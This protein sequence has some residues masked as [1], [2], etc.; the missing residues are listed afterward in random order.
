MSDVSKNKDDEKKPKIVRVTNTP[1]KRKK[2]PTSKN[3]K[4]NVTIVSV[5]E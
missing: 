4:S 5:G 3:T 2:V 1:V